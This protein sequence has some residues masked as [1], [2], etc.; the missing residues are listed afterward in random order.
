MDVGWQVL[1]FAALMERELLANAHKDDHPLSHDRAHLLDELRGHVEKF[2]VEPTDEHA[3]DVANLAMLALAAVP[4]AGTDG[5]WKVRCAFCGST[6]WERL[7][8]DGCS[9]CLTA[10][11]TAEDTG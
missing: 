10:G 11:S 6:Q 1:A 7:T 4:A 8:E 3:A 2:A 9:E 5:E